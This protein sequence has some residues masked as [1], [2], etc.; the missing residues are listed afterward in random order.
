MTSAY[1]NNIEY[2]RSLQEKYEYYQAGLNFTLLALS[3][4]TASFDGSRLQ[5]ALELSGWVALLIA[6]VI[7][8]ARFRMQPVAHKN[9]ALIDKKKAMLRQFI[10]GRDRGSR[11]VLYEDEGEVVPI[12]QAIE[13]AEK[14][15]EKNEPKVKELEQRLINQH[16]WHL[17]LFVIGLGLIML[18]RAVHPLGILVCGQGGT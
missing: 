2:A 16:R 8:L 1:R 5:A 17:W 15:I 6:G 13:E 4:Q 14:S 18:S 12:E 10:A 3:V 9:Y 7:A 11:E